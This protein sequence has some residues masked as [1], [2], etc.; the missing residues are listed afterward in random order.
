MDR[1]EQEVQRIICAGTESCAMGIIKKWP[2]LDK[3]YNAQSVRC[4]AGFVKDPRG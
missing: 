1:R 3:C 4:V 2:F